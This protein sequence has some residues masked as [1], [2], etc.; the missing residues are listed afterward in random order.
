MPTTKISP[1]FPWPS[2]APSCTWLYTTSPLPKAST[3]S[4]PFAPSTKFALVST[5]DIGSLVERQ[6]QQKIPKQVTTVPKC[7]LHLSWHMSVK[8]LI[9][10]TTRPICV[11]KASENHLA[12]LAKKWSWRLVYKR[13]SFR[14]GGCERENAVNL[15][16]ACTR[17]LAI[18]RNTKTYEFKKWPISAG[19]TR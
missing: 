6:W 14:F 7:S 17:N 16:S 13:S 5:R 2:N 9:Q 4:P 12:L 10:P 3:T 1:T 8:L 11:Q 18:S 15:Y 19:T